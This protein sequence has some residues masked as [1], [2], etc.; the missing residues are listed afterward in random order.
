LGSLFGLQVES[1]AGWRW[2]WTGEVLFSCSSSS[3]SVVMMWMIIG[4]IDGVM[5]TPRGKQG[6]SK[7][8]QLQFSFWQGEQKGA[9]HN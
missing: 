4:A 2:C 8:E 9:V 1:K 6:T 5:R 7:E 3:V